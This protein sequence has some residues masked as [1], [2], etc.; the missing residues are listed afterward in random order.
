MLLGIY[1]AFREQPTEGLKSVSVEVILSDGQGEIYETSTNAEFLR[2]VLDE[3]DGITYSETVNGFGPMVTEVNG[4]R[5]VYEENG[6]YWAFFVNGEYCNYG[7]SDQPVN[8]GDAFRIEY[9]KA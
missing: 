2:G 5:A 1:Y 6:A 9:T 4:E 3:I 8:D 7:I